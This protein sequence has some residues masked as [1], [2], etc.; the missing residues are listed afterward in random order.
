MRKLVPPL[1]VRRRVHRH[2]VEHYTNVDKRGIHKAITIL[3]R[4]YRVRRPKCI[5]WYEYIDNGTTLGRIY[6][7]GK[8]AMVHPENWKLSPREWLKTIYHEFDHYL[9][10]HEMEKK[11]DEYAE[12]MLRGCETRV[13]V[14]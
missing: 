1:D 4:F 6:E 13:K 7:D 5:E 14:K 9:H 3:C 12:H 8:I 2:L 10:W 11:A